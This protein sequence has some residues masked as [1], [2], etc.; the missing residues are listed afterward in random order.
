M[1]VDAMTL[2]SGCWLRGDAESS[3][4][5][6]SLLLL[7]DQVVQRLDTLTLEDGVEMGVAPDARST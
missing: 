6:L 2:L 1:A 7:V 4:R 3:V 5:S